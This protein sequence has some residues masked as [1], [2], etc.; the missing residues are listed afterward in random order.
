MQGCPLRPA[1]SLLTHVW[2][3]RATKDDLWFLQ[4]RL[5]LA[6][7]YHLLTR[8]L[9]LLPQRVRHSHQWLKTG[10]WDSKFLAEICATEAEEQTDSEQVKILEQGMNFKQPCMT[11]SEHLLKSLSFSPLSYVLPDHYALWALPGTRSY[12]TTCRQPGGQH[13]QPPPHKA[14]H[15]LI[16][17]L[18]TAEPFT[19]T[20][21]TSHHQNQCMN[22][23]QASTRQEI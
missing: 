1:G 5:I 15:V 20:C 11:C 18:L 21:N 16:P 22:P 3:V 8:C 13:Q 10:L 12:H 4:L 6:H 7:K 14:P 9:G 19:V 23:S 2:G 17:T